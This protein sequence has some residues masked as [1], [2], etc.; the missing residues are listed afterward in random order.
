MG[1]VRGS[2]SVSDVSVL[3][4]GGDVTGMVRGNAMELIAIVLDSVR[5]A[6]DLAVRNAV[7]MNAMDPR[8]RALTLRCANE[9]VDF[10]TAPARP[11]EA[12]RENVS[13]EVSFETRKK[14]QL[15]NQDLSKPAASSVTCGATPPSA[16]ECKLSHANSAHRSLRAAA[17]FS[18]SIPPRNLNFFVT[19]N[20]WN[21]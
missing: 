12:R 5:D 20:A 9:E 6:T 1:V 16:T 8:V 3:G 19:S 17:G 15:R 11:C 14:R 7:D 4:H 2:R 13:H 21:N 10:V 18:S